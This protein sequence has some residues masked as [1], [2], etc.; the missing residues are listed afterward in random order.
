MCIRKNV[1]QEDKIINLYLITAQGK[2]LDEHCWDVYGIGTR[3][4]NPELIMSSLHLS[5]R[6]T[7]Q[8]QIMR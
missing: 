1:N 2:K 5:P 7:F 3:N 6:H 4:D 8:E